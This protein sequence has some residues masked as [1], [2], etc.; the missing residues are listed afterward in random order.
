MTA[1]LGN[2]TC[3]DDIHDQVK[4]QYFTAGRQHAR[5]H[6]AFTCMETQLA[7]KMMEGPQAAFLVQK[8]QGLFDALHD[9]DKTMQ[10]KKDSLPETTRSSEDVLER[11]KL[12]YFKAGLEYARKHFMSACMEMQ[13]SARS[14]QGFDAEFLAQKS[15]GIFDAL[16]DLS[17][18][19]Q[20]DNMKL[21][22][23]VRKVDLE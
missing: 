23:I 4:I 8:A 9:F 13:L 19:L 5:K 16:Y 20:E 1:D 14:V 2:G 15:Q 12:F 21:Q 10:E 11:L 22:K 3:I 7:A 6:F 18:L 17:K